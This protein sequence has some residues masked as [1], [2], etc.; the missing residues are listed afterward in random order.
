VGEVA[1]DPVLQTGVG[2]ARP[3]RRAVLGHQVHKLLADIPEGKKVGEGLE[4]FN[5]NVKF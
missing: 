2:T 5:A 1:L 4:F 3:Q